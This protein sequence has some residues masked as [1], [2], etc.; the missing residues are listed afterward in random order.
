MFH[1]SLLLQS[2]L[3]QFAVDEQ[4][5]KNDVANFDD[6]EWHNEMKTRTKRWRVSSRGKRLS[7]T[8]FKLF[9]KYFPY[10]FDFIHTSSGRHLQ[11]NNSTQLVTK[12][13]IVKGTHKMQSSIKS[14]TAA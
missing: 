2:N 9:I 5:A 4:R 7:S 10:S 12:R 14:T 3:L 6:D 13:Q 8:A 11:V 1:V